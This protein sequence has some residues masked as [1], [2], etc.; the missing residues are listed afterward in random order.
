MKGVTD[1]K[2]HHSCTYLQRKFKL[3]YTTSKL[4]VEIIKELELEKVWFDPSE[5][6]PDLMKPV[7]VEGKQYR[8]QAGPVNSKAECDF[9]IAH[10]DG[11]FGWVNED[12]GEILCVEKWMKIPDEKEEDSTNE[13]TNV[14]KSLSKVN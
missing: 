5:K 4:V 6:I 13:I 8:R 1:K 3:D 10:L 12:N 2:L 11:H 14:D 7:I 9:H